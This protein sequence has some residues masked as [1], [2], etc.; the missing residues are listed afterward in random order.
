VIELLN[1]LTREAVDVFEA[2]TQVILAYLFGSRARGIETP[3]SDTDIAILLSEVPK[4]L[5]ELYLYLIDKLSIALGNEIDLIILNTSPPLLKHQ[6]I[7]HGRAIY[8]R[9]EKARV[10]FESR[11]EKEYLDFKIYR[12][13]YDKALIK[14]IS[15]WKTKF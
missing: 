15:T 11:A 3:R 13:R 14:E 10:E 7:K 1:S 5:L 9:E 12:D 4:N 2:E 6:V 8:C